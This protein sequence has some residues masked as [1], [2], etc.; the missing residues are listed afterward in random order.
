MNDPKISFS[1]FE[2]LVDWV[3]HEREGN[4][5]AHLL[6][7]AHLVEFAPPLLDLRLSKNFPQEL[8]QHLQTLLKKKTGEDWTIAISDKIGQPTLHEREQQVQEE[9]QNAIKETPVVKL[10]LEAFPGT[11]LVQMKDM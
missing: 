9:Q 11:T 10:L 1:S 2:A 4:L 7:D 8:L 6:Y 3:G 5:H